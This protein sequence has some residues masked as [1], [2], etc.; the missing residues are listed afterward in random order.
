MYVDDR[1][2]SRGATE[3][4]KWATEISKWSTDISNVLLGGFNIF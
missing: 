1:G 3:I 2:T 4:S